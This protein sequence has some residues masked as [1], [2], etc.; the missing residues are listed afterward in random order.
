M[1]IRG[2]AD[3]IKGWSFTFSE[4]CWIRLDF[5]LFT[6]AGPNTVTANGPG[7]GAPEGTCTDS[8]EISVGF[9]SNTKSVNMIHDKENDFRVRTRIDTPRF[10]EKT[11]DSTVRSEV[12]DN[13]TMPSCFYLKQCTSSSGTKRRATRRRSHSTSI[14]P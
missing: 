3:I 2:F 10:A 9:P 14:P 4:V 5:D 12:N 13:E 7:P 6:L 11:L 8:M 1:I